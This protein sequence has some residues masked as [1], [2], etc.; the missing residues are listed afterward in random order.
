MFYGWT[1]FRSSLRS[2]LFF[3]PGAL[4]L[5]PA[6]AA[7]AGRAEIAM[8]P[9]LPA[10]LAFAW[11]VAQ[12]LSPPALPI[13]ARGVSG[14][15][16]WTGLADARASCAWILGSAA[17]VAVGATFWVPAADLLGIRW[18]ESGSAFATWLLTLEAAVGCSF[19]VW[20]LA[21]LLP[22]AAA[23]AASGAWLLLNCADPLATSPVGHL[24]GVLAFP[25]SSSRFAVDEAAHLGSVLRALGCGLSF[26]VGMLALLVAWQGRR[27]R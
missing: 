12:M 11:I 16:R 25:V 26:D 19:V 9:P 4:A 20:L 7:R 17:S 22:A 2:G 5:F 8:P 1:A 10:A 13:L 18:V 3:L 23:T 14:P 24:A 15:S 27:A 6:L 21:S